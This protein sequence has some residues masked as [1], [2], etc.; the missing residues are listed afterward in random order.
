M[1][2]ALLRSTAGAGSRT[3]LPE[4]GAAERDRDGHECAED[5]QEPEQ[6][7]SYDPATAQCLSRLPPRDPLILVALSYP[8]LP[9]RCQ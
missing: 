4:S 1:A 2:P 8:P 3:T 5:G 7:S 9:E 6:T